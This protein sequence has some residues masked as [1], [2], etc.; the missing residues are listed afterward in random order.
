VI[1]KWEIS[2]QSYCFKCYRNASLEKKVTFCLLLVFPSWENNWHLCFYPLQ[3][4]SIGQE[5]EM[6]RKCMCDRY[7]IFQICCV[8]FVKNMTFGITRGCLKRWSKYLLI[9]MLSGSYRMRVLE[10]LAVEK[11]TYFAMQYPT[12]FLSSLIMR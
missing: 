8:L 9:S 2:Y 6:T 12:Q 4:V 7:Q 3:S 5:T 10:N 1:W 11:N